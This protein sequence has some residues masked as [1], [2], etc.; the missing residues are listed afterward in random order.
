LED[1]PG[2]LKV[3]LFAMPLPYIALQAGWIVTEVGRQPWIV[4]GLMKTKDAVSPIAAS[5]VGVTLAAFIVIYS[6]LGAVAFYLV[7][8]HA[9]RGPAPVKV[10]G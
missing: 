8:K 7:A 1:S 5:Q 10:E 4:Y 9:R 2:L 3:M 6:L